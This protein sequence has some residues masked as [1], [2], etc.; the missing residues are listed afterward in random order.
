MLAAAIAVCTIGLGAGPAGAS[1]S[2]PVAYHVRATDASTRE[3]LRTGAIQ[4]GTFR[5]LLG[6]LALSDLIVYVGTVD[7]IAGGAAGQLSFTLATPTVRYVRIELAATGNVREMIALVA[8]E[9]QHAVEIAAAPQV[10]DPQAMALLYLG[11]GQGGDHA[12]HESRAARVIEAR[13]RTEL[14]GFRL[15]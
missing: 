15:E 1:V 6:R 2:D 3:W 7:R 9:L 13:V 4:S 11:M 5:A 10:R 8:H 12:R 14:A